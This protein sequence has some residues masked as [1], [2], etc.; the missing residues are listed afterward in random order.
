MS[1]LPNRTWLR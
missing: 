1:L